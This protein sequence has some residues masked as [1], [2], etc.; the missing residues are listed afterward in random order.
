MTMN[1]IKIKFPDGSEREF[2]SGV[3]PL[4][5]AQS[6]SRKLAEEALFVILMGLLKNYLL[7]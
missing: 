4:Q 5:I 6:I 1:K 2:D 3:T 7:L